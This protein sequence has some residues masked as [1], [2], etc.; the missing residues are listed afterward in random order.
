MATLV[1]SHT[2]AAAADG[3]GPAPGLKQID[4]YRGV[5]RHW[6]IR[7][8][9]V[10]LVALLWPLVHALYLLAAS[11]AVPDVPLLFPVAQTSRC[12]GV[13]TPVM[14]RAQGQL[15]SLYGLVPLS[16]LLLLLVGFLVCD[17]AAAPTC[18][19]TLD[20]VW[21]DVREVPRVR[22]SSA[23]ASSAHATSRDTRHVDD[24]GR[25][26]FAR[27]D[28]VRDASAAVPL[29]VPLLDPTEMPRRP[30]AAVRNR[31][32]L[33]ATSVEIWSSPPPRPTPHAQ[34]HDDDTASTL[35]TVPPSE[36]TV[37]S[38]WSALVGAGT[39]CVVCLARR[40]VVALP[41]GHQCLCGGCAARVRRADDPRCP[42]CR[43]PAC[44]R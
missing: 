33:S 8:S 31:A 38:E 41:C 7:D 14:L 20:L 43:H 10:A 23:L 29:A 13:A 6:A 40:A 39:G 36:A 9:N 12:A 19:R 15:D 22:P 24:D 21:L 18:T 4:Q 27:W 17:R 1:F 32:S 42:L 34:A 30:T 2:L 37:G 25:A 11:R 35:S 5:Y 26:A 28:V 16:G 44:G 3:I